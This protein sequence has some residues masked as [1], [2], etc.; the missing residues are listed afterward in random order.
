MNRVARLV[1][2]LIKLYLLVHLPIGILL[3]SQ[4]GAGPIC[5]PGIMRWLR[6]TAGR[7]LKLPLRPR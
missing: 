2:A 3:D 6:C 1:D 4:S 5:V 7:L